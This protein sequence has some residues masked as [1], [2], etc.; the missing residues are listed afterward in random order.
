MTL[1]VV[2][3]VG[4]ADLDVVTAQPG[5]GAESFQLRAALLHQLR[6]RGDTGEV[7]RLMLRGGWDDGHASTGRPAPLPQVLAALAASDPGVPVRLLLLGTRQDPPR[8]RDTH[9]VAEALAVAVREGAAWLPV[10]VAKV[11]TVTATGHAEALVIDALGAALPDRGAPGD[12]AAVTWGSGPSALALGAV[13]ALVRAGLP[14]RLV[15]LPPQRDPRVVDPLEAPEVDPVVALLVRWRMFPALHH[16]ATTDPPAVRLTP[17]QALLVERLAQ[18]WQDGY[19]AKGAAALEGLVRD[20]LVR[21]DGTAGIA[22]RR[23][24]EARYTEWLAA[25]RAVDP[26]A[27]ELLAW[28]RDHGTEHRRT[29]GKRV[30]YLREARTTRELGPEAERDSARWLRGNA[31]AELIEIGKASHSLDTA[32]PER[33]RRAFTALGPDTDAE[34][35]R[36]VGL[37]APAAGAGPALFAVWVAGVRQPDD[38]RP[39]VGAQL[40]DEGFGTVVQRHLG[41]RPGADGH[42]RAVSFTALVVGVDGSI[43][44]ATE[45]SRE[46]FGLPRPELL[47]RLNATDAVITGPDDPDADTR[48]TRVVADA[49]PEEAEALLLVP[50]GRKDQLLPLLRAARRISAERGLPMFLR[51]LSAAPDRPPGVHLWPALTGGDRPLLIAALEAVAALELDAAWRLLMA[52]SLAGTAGVRCQELATAFACREPD[53]PELWP[54]PLR[55]EPFT[56]YERVLPMMA[57]RLRLVH[58]VHTS[59]GRPVPPGASARFL[60][61]AA[62]A[63]EASVG[64]ATTVPGHLA[65][66]RF[67]DQLTDLGHGDPCRPGTIAARVLWLLNAARDQAPVTHGRDPDP[68]AA[69]AAARGHLP[70]AWR[71]ADTPPLDRI[72]DVETL[73]AESIAATER[74]VVTTHDRAVTD[75]VAPYSDLLATLAVEIHRRTPT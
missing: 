22:V 14:W 7:A 16:L 41:V 68:D 61:L 29:L 19:Q 67:H 23:Y 21:R 1:W 37:P 24:V 72:R 56:G 59:P 66:R 17:A 45:Q 2:H 53:R 12:R 4:A 32:A 74:L 28:A 46:L 35:L 54:E 34:E 47:G 63:V 65:S 13:T 44:A 43:A 52:T 10:E 48:A 18:R 33:V 6:H 31:V 60:V 25:E 11:R 20:A 15:E 5:G 71:E 3:P 40:L 73:I 39:S 51:E 27:V 38:T 30:A 49:L 42:R 57:D 75:L 9:Q 36:R 69:V 64:E 50:T 55:R 8:A 26:G 70:P 58:H 62:S